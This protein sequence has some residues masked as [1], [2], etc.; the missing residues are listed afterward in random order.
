MCKNADFLTPSY[1]ESIL[2]RRDQ[3]LRY[4]DEKAA[5]KERVALSMKIPLLST[6]PFFGVHYDHSFGKRV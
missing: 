4:F 5:F 3:V 6:G 1:L 2:E